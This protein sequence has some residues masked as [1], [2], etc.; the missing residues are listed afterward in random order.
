MEKGEGVYAVVVTFNPCVDQ[1]GNLLAALGPQVQSII[2]VDNGSANGVLAD[3][4]R[5]CDLPA[6]DLIR[7]GANKGIAFAQN[8]GIQAAR[9]AGAKYVVLF[10]H[11]SC[12]APDMVF[13][14]RAVAEAKAALGIKVGGVGARYFD[15]RQDNPPPFIQV[16]GLKVERQPCQCDGSVVAVDYLIASGC[17]I[18]LN[19]LDAVGEMNEELFIDYVDIEW[20]LRAKANGFLSFGV[21]AAKMA[22]DLGDEPIVFLGKSYPAHSPLRHYYHFRNAVWM[23]RQSWLPL[24]WK[25]ADGWR[26]IL[27]YGFYS[28]LAHPRSMHW[29]MMT[30]GIAHGLRG[31]MGRLV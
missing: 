21:C 8:V 23:Y 4:N 22:H 26:L 24:H 2:V 14:L 17:L 9:R 10:D 20:G 12:P 27:K 31:K 18:P 28:L 29:R 1:F 16:V 30:K 6:I 13:Q 5:L 7:L 11:D 25:L 15:D 3:L 19:T